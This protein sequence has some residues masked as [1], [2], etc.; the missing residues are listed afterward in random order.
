MPENRTF[1]KEEIRII[2]NRASEIQ[3]Q[4][5]LYGDKEGLSEAELLEVANEVGIDKSSLLEAL[6]KLNET[7]FN[8]TFNWLKGTS[9]LQ[10]INYADGEINEKLWDEVIQEIRKINGGI[11]KISHVGSTYEWEQRMQEIGYKHIS[12]T[13]QKGKTKIQYVSS[14]APLR[15]LILFMGSFLFGVLMLIALKGIGIPKSTAVL[16]SPIGGLI[17]FSTG[18]IYLKSRF[19]KEKRRLK[20]IINS[21]SKKINDLS[22][23]SIVIEDEILD[24]NSENEKSVRDRVKS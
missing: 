1:N 12:F 19:E 10:R 23:P 13:P 11:G 3:T 4:K 9:R 22:N 14:W 8:D 6:N 7:E 20:N 24:D 2:L 15:F 21:V 16:F 18:M 17:G 5:D